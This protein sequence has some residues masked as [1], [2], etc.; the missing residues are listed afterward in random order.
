MSST[1][2]LS[3]SFDAVGY[4]DLPHV[5]S[6]QARAAI[7]ST[8]IMDIGK[9]ITDFNLH[10]YFGLGLAH[11][12]FL[13]NQDEQAVISLANYD[14]VKFEVN[15][16]PC[17]ADRPA[18]TWFPVSNDEISSSQVYMPVLY[19]DESLIDKAKSAAEALALVADTFLP[20]L[21]AAINAS[22]LCGRIGL[23]TRL[24]GEEI[25][26]E[27]LEE[28]K[29]SVRQQTFKIMA[30]NDERRPLSLSTMWFFNHILGPDGVMTYGCSSCN[31]WGGNGW[32]NH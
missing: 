28:T 22:G 18:C 29:E 23:V 11:R 30:P 16:Q 24:Q 3:N 26:A 7:D 1:M 19:V 32:G 4:L 27:F 13:I 12:H 20:A 6:P 25:T 21:A 10:K 8:K 2:I 14:D 5:D 31:C 9:V 17:Q 15:V